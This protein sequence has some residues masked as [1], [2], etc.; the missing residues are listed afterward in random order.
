MTERIEP[1]GEPCFLVGPE[2]AG[3]TVLRLMLDGHPKVAWC[4]EMQYIVSQLPAKGWPRVEEFAAW[5]LEQ[6]VFLDTGLRIDRRLS[7]PELANSFLR[8]KLSW[9][10]NGKAIV[11]ATCHFHFDRLLRIWPDAKF[12]HLLRDGRD[13]AQWC[14]E[15]GWA[16][17][18]WAGAEAWVE[19][20]ALWDRLCARV[21]ED[22]RLEVRYEDLMRDAVPALT[23][24]CRFLG[25]EY[26]PA[27]L[28]YAPHS[29]YDKPSAG[30]VEPWRRALSSE[31]VRLVEARIGPLLTARGYAWSGFPAVAVG[32]K[33]ERRLRREDRLGRLRFGFRR[34]GAWL[35]LSGYI[36]RRL[37]L[38]SWNQSIRV[39]RHA[40]DQA[41]LK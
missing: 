10:G 4:S 16:G 35:M 23:R 31:E 18:A 37:G 22:R 13:V 39:R 14:V 40:I 27:L 17:N 21:P 1:V 15:M 33:L 11:G 3:A 19:A 12:I 7:Y 20:E 5:L 41:A 36:A 6:R 24:I 32:P 9:G 25:T 38:K 29:A 34:Y 26:D 28:D 8:Q 2:H 30:Y